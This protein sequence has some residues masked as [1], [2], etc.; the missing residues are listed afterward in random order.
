MIHKLGYYKQAK[1]FTNQHFGD[2]ALCIGVFVTE[3]I[4]TNFVIHPYDRFEPT[5]FQLVEYPLLKDIVPTWA[6]LMIALLIPLAVFAGF[7]LYYRNMHD[8]HHAF[9]GLFET[10]TMTLLFTDFLKVIAGRY[11]PDYLARVETNDQSLIR[12]GRMSFPSGHSSLSFA[13]MTYLS[14]YLCGKLRVFRKEGAAMWKILIV[15]SPYAISSLVAVSRTVDYHHDFSDILA[16]TLIGL[17]IGSF[18]YF[19]NYN[20][21]ASKECSLPKNRINPNYAKDGLLFAENTYTSLSMTHTTFITIFRNIV[22]RN[23][24]FNSLEDTRLSYDVGVKKGGGVYN[25]SIKGRELIERSK[26]DPLCLLRF[27]LPWSFIRYYLPIPLSTKDDLFVDRDKRSKAIN[28]Y[29]KHQNATLDTLQHLIDDWSPDFIPD[30][31]IIKSLSKRGALDIIIFLH[32]R[33]SHA[34][35]KEICDRKN[36]LVCNSAMHH[37][38]DA[39]HLNV[40]EYLYQ[41]C[42]YQPY[43]FT[44]STAARNGHL[45]VV[46]WLQDHYSDTLDTAGDE[47]FSPLASAISCGRLDLVEYLHKTRTESCKPRHMDEASSGGFID[48]VKFLHQHRS[49]GCT[50]GAIDGAAAGG[51]IKIVEF[52]FRNRTEGCTDK[53]MQMAV[54]GGH[55]E[56]VQFLYQNKPGISMAY[57]M[58]TAAAHGHLNIL[59]YL[60]NNVKDPT[61]CSMD[62]LASPARKGYT[63]IVRFLCENRPRCCKKKGIISAVV[64][65]HFDM[66]KYLFSIGATI[67]V[68]AI[69]LAVRN[70][71]EMVTY[72][73]ENGHS[74]STLAMDYAAELGNL[75]LVQFLHFNR[76]EGCTVNAM[77]KAS[78]AGFLNVVEWLH[79]N[80]SEGC[81]TD[82]MDGAAEYSHMSVL[83]FLHFNRTEGCTTEAMDNA[84]FKSFEIVEFLD[85]HRSEGCTPNAMDI[86]ALSGRSNIIKL[87]HYNRTE[88]CTTTTLD[89]VAKSAANTG[90]LTMLKLISENRTEGC[91]T[92]AMDN[93][94]KSIPVLEYLSKNRSEGCTT[95]AMDLAMEHGYLN[96]VEWLHHNRTEGG[97]SNGVDQAARNDH[98]DVLKF[99]VENRTEGKST[100]YEK[101]IQ[102]ANFFGN[103]TISLFL[104]DQLNK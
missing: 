40:I 1:W 76:T 50:S 80:R 84:S 14:F 42:S 68:N 36:R 61:L 82:A 65:G 59:E 94:F 99:V 41:N 92:N 103:I 17:C 29:I 45:H 66:A 75:P 100:S 78:I 55:L 20:T 67:T 9:L 31:H 22:I 37:A 77:N 27:A 71:L 26:T 96:V 43:Q 73:H 6:L 87:L 23:N 72:L 44:M 39:G 18:I 70:G 16:G 86:A 52:L 30:D 11:R 62:V 53:A 4:L 10:F 19:M 15:M 89:C 7:Y 56:V 49:E 57:M 32:K 47:A 90:D 95:N 35:N 60:Q 83:E 79:H 81:T 5:G 85:K 3:Q 38:A 63:E 8:F 91:T 97:T 88:G 54:R 51:H 64:E 98:L 104:Q 2:W 58:D 28:K 46:K 21:L 48:V 25:Q 69:D 24:I 102:N 93:A 34:D 13:S 101:A 12:D 74:A 33:Y